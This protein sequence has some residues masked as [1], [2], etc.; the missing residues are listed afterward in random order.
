MNNT[1]EKVIKQYINKIKSVFPTFYPKKR[2]I[3]LELKQNLNCY[4]IEHDNFT[5]EEL[6]NEFGSPQEYVGAIVSNTSEEELLQNIKMKRRTTFILCI[7]SIFILGVGIASTVIIIKIT[8][9]FPTHYTTEI[10]EEVTHIPT[11]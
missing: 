5:I 7:I 2:K 1:Q 4:C 9:K 3:L 6:Y 11:K 10:I 8:S